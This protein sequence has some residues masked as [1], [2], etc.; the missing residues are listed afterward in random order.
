MK[1]S[2]VTRSLLAAVSIVALTAVMYGCVHSDDDDPVTGMEDDMMPGDG[3]GDGDG[4]DM[5]PTPEAVMLPADLM[6][7]G[8]DDM[9]MAGETMIAAGRSHTSGGVE[10][11]CAAGGDDCVLTVDANGMATSTGGTV[12][13]ALTEAAMERVSD[14]KIDH[15][16][17]IIGLD[18]ALEGASN[19]GL[20]G[21]AGLDE[22]EITISRAAGA[23]AR[24]TS[25]GYSAS[26][27]TI[28]DNGGWAG[29]LL[30][31]S[32]TGATQYLAVYTD[33]AA[34]TRVQFYNFDD[35]EDTLHLY[36]AADTDDAAALS[37]QGATG[38]AGPLAVIVNAALLDMT[39]FPAP[40]PVQ[41]G[42]VMQ[43]YAVNNDSDDDGTLD[44]VSIPGNFNG[45]GG[46]YIC[47]AT[48]PADGCS[49]TV[50]PGGAYTLA[51]GTWTFVP[52][53][54][55]TAWRQDDEFMQFGWWLQEPTAATG[56]YTFQYFAD[57]DAYAAPATSNLLAAGSAEYT[58]RAAGQYVVQT[59]DDTGVTG[60]MGGQFV[61]AA[62]LTATFTNTEGAD[63]TIEGRITGFEGENGRMLGWS[64]MLNEQSF[65]SAAE[66]TSVTSLTGTSDPT[67]PGFDGATATMGDHTAH[68]TWTSQFFGQPTTA[69]AYPLGVGGTF[70][71]DSEAVSIA[72]SFGARRPTE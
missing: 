62:S 12:T 26:D 65:T 68:G 28:L 46:R 17:R 47:D 16:D 29:T 9:P 25:T 42:N 70:Q 30:E 66:D 50:T 21:T 7:L 37:L 11:T 52:E 8:A 48:A 55:A 2:K 69:N 53:L 60:G 10:F 3:D 1:K 61:A 44:E 49:V 39:R 64:V 71:A 33:I 5:E 19:L 38:T 24:V 51:G 35:D 13:T 59:I 36:G 34:P 20:T 27:D 31:R 67:A 32:V 54:N 72:G 4:D 40:G 58:G 63:G 57:G 43:P 14:A 15:R 41:E 22:D 6:Y 45:A 56:A 23:M 18:R